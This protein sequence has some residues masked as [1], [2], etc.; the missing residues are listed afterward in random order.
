MAR[1]A[2]K[3]SRQFRL[4][5]PLFWIARTDCC[6]RTIRFET[7]TRTALETLS[8]SPDFFGQYALPITSIA[9]SADLRQTFVAGTFNSVNGLALKT[10]V[11]LDVLGDLDL[12]FQA[13]PT[14]AAT[15]QTGL[16]IKLQPDEKI[17]VSGAVGPSD[18]LVRRR[19]ILRLTEDGE[20]DTD[21]SGLEVNYSSNVRALELLPD[22]KIL[23]AGNFTSP[24]AALNGLVR[25]NQWNDQAFVRLCDAKCDD[26]C[27]GG[28][29]DGK[30]SWRF[31]SDRRSR[32]TP[33]PGAIG[34]E[35]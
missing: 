31:I 20:L 35:R 23:V 7:Q 1:T 11:R 29:S 30:M 24:A 5:Q 17:L 4:L 12:A 13:S 2:F 22:G 27:A 14:V 9:T 26:Q 15:F 32:S 16:I 34:Y 28:Q 33:K 25:L 3:I 18:P 21:F 6:C 8:F 10:L 19:L